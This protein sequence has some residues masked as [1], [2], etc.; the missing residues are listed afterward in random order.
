MVVMG[1]VYH[2]VCVDCSERRQS[3]TNNG[4]QS[5]KDVINDIDDIRLATTNVDPSNKEENPC[6]TEQ[7]D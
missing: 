1:Y 4:E 7:S 3:I 6:K 5:D 2:V